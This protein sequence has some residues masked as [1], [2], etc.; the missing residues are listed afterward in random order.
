MAD[1]A[2]MRSRVAARR[3]LDARAL[4]QAVGM[5]DTE[6]T[7]VFGG[8]QPS[9]ALLRRLAPVFGLHASD[10]FLVAGVRVPDDLAPAVPSPGGLDSLVWDLVYLPQVGQRVHELLR[11]MVGQVGTQ[12][13]GEREYDKWWLPGFGAVL[14][15]LFGN[16]NMSVSCTVKVLYDL[17]GLGPWAASTLNK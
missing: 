12:P 9:A 2:G 16:R 17:T 5:P 3:G 1:F 6:L 15:R 13:A 11:T 14:M 10:L 7:A 4:A 8:T